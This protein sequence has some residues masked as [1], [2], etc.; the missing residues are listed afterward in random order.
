MNPL[1]IYRD[2]DNKSYQ[3]IKEWAETTGL[4]GKIP[5]CMHTTVVSNTK[6]VDVTLVELDMTPITARISLDA[7]TIKIF[8]EASHVIVF[9]SE[10]LTA[11]EKYIHTLLDLT[12]A[13][14]YVPHIS[15][16]YC[17]TSQQSPPPPNITL[18]IALGHEQFGNVFIPE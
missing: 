5:R 6:P 9:E 3:I 2:I 7:K 10:E 1:A 18:S 15:F 16:M 4:E 11:R 14:D 12:R 13:F 17:E 8:G